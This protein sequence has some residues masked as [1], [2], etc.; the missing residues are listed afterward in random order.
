MAFKMA[1]IEII[2]IWKVF[3]NVCHIWVTG[4][5]SIVLL[6]ILPS[7]DVDSYV[8]GFCS[9]CALPNIGYHYYYFIINNNITDYVHHTNRKIGSLDCV[10][11]DYVDSVRERSK[12]RWN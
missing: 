2:L 6:V 8:T 11:D 10:A 1:K 5:K 4:R 9:F 7:S 12:F 3:Y